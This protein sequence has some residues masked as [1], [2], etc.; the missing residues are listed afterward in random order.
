MKKGIFILLFL[1]L[2]TSI[3]A[4]AGTPLIWAGAFHLYI[5]N[6]FVGIFETILLIK[7]KVRYKIYVIGIIIIVAN[8]VSMSVG[9]FLSDNI[10]HILKFDYF[11]PR[12]QEYIWQ[13]ILLYVS[14]TLT[15][16]I[17]ELP[18]FF[19]VL[20]KQKII[21]KIIIAFKINCWSALVVLIYYI[22]FQWGIINLI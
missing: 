4:N 7:Q 10:G 6:I 19:W 11:N 5:G 3:Y 1:I 2:S 13:N 18:F 15:S 16:F 8:F 12:D 20:E 14:L 17:V 22:V 9:W 21:S